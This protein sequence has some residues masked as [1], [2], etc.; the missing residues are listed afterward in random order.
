M[1]TQPLKRCPSIPV[2]REISRKPSSAVKAAAKLDKEAQGRDWT[3]KKRAT[4]RKSL[5]RRPFGM[6]S[7]VSRPSVI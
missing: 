6:L 1:R 2:R 5:K 3:K 7:L 4:F